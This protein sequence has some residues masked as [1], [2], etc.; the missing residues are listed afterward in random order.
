M[1]FSL[2]LAISALLL[3]GCQTIPLAQQEV[4]LAIEDVTVIDPESGR[5][6]QHRTVYV[7]E[8]RIVGIS[9]ARLRQPITAPTRVNGAVAF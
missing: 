6:S 2:K 9:D 8:G 5:V 1:R 7:D 4:D 3:S